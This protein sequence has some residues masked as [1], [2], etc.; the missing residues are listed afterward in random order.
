MQHPVFWE[1]LPSKC[2]RGLCDIYPVNGKQRLWTRDKPSAHWQNISF[3]SPI[4][5]FS[6]K[7]TAQTLE[8]DPKQ[9]TKD[10]EYADAWFRSELNK[11]S[12]E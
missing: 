11:E 4:T 12:F 3:F 1:E 9:G 6:V 8:A 10:W 7:Q 2:I 5:R